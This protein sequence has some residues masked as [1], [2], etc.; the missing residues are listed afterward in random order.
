MDSERD[1]DRERKRD[2]D[3]VRQTNREY[4]KTFKSCLLYFQRYYCPIARFY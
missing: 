1:I 4:K 2:R 3:K